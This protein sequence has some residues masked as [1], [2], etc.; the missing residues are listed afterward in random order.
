VTGPTTADSVVSTYSG[1]VSLG[2]QYGFGRRFSVWG[3]LGGSYTRTN[4]ASTSTFATTVTA[5]LNNVTAQVITLQTIH[6]SGR[7]NQYAT[8]AAV[9]VILFF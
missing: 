5:T 1:A 3:E 2:A 9:G 8:R 7:T 4:I 6:G